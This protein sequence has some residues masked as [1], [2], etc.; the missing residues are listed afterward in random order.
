MTIFE[1]ACRILE[2][3]VAAFEADGRPFKRAY[4][5]DGSANWEFRPSLI[6]EWD[7][8]ETALL[9]EA[10]ARPSDMSSGNLVMQAAFTIHALRDTVWP[11]S[12]EAGNPPEPHQIQ[13]N[14]HLVMCDAETIVSTLLR[15][16][17][18]GALFGA[19]GRMF[20]V[21]QAAVVPEGG[22]VGSETKVLVML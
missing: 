16:M 5:S 18:S 12:D 15:T 9:A 4:A 10:E 21:N 13:Q 14:A 1:A 7:G 8:R 2:T 3:L 20:F 17:G 11:A 6:V 19:C 22:V